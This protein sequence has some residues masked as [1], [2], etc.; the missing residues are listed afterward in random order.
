[1]ELRSKGEDRREREKFYLKMAKKEGLTG[2][3]LEGFMHKLG[4]KEY[5]KRSRSIFEYL[6][7]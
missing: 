3:R 2:D 4:F 6:I 1:M 5:K 7:K